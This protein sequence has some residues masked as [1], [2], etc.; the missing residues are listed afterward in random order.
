VRRASERRSASA[1][2]AVIAVIRLAGR[3]LARSR[4]GWSR[5]VRGSGLVRRQCAALRSSDLFDPIAY[6]TSPPAAAVAASY[7]PARRA[8]TRRS[9]HPLVIRFASRRSSCVVRVRRS[10]C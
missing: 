8:G 7:V 3:T 4:P 5:A 10:T 9:G 2:R 6:L 1:A